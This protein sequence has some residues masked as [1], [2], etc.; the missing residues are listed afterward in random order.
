MKTTVIQVQE[1]EN[2]IEIS[3]FGIQLVNHLTYTVKDGNGKKYNLTIIHD[4]TYAIFEN[5]TLRFSK[6]VKLGTYDR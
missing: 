5:G 1:V 2:E 4:S 3:Y 6:P